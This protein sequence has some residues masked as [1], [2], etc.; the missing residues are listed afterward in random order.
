MLPLHRPSPGREVALEAPH[1]LD[2]PM[3]PAGAADECTAPDWERYVVEVRGRRR[4]RHAMLSLPEHQ[5]ARNRCA[6]TVLDI[7]ARRHRATSLDPALSV[8]LANEPQVLERPEAAIRLVR[9]QWSA[10]VRKLED[11]CDAGLRPAL[12][13]R[14]ALVRHRNP[15]RH[16]LS[17]G[18]IRSRVVPASN[19]V[20]TR[21]TDH[22][23][24]RCTRL[25]PQATG[26]TRTSPMRTR[27]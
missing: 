22:N 17:P 6:G 15:A 24:R 1:R 20:R 27:T 11:L 9:E 16:T 21:G 19:G 10:A 13:T 7:A 18:A 25:R 8:P 4:E 2:R 14:A 5:L 3:S 12:P 26:T 23:R